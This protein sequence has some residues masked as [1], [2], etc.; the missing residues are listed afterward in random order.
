M[1]HFV[2]SDNTTHR[3][4]GA[5][6]KVIDEIKKAGVCPFC[7]EN[8]SK[9]HKNPVLKEGKYWV[10]TKNFYPYE[11]AKHH[12]LI[13]HKKHIETFEEIIPEAWEEIRSLIGS[14]LKNEKIIG[15]TFVMRF[16]DTAHT[17]AS[18]SHLHANLVSP[19]VE[20]KN[21]K[22]ILARIG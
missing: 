16:G 5:Y 7:P 15:G 14:F 12:I 19:D 4:S 6:G 2:N 22:P 13:I 9:Y 10:L 17:G 21:R 18:V 20:D 1:A 8:L 3:P 11:G